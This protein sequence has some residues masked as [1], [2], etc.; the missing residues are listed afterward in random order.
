VIPCL[1]D[2]A[3]FDGTLVSVLQNRPA[4]CEI[5]VA[6]R[7][8]YDDPYGL[9]DEVNFLHCEGESLVELLNEA[10]TEASGE[11]LNIL[12]CGLEATENWT[13]APLAHF[14]DP[15]VASVS[16]LV[17]DRDQNLLA[18][19]VYCSL[20]GACRIAAN[21][22]V[23]EPG[24]GRLRAKILGPTLTAGFYRRD[25]IAALGGFDPTMTDQLA[26]VATALSLEALG[27]LHVVEPAS[28]LTKISD[29]STQKR[30]SLYR[31]RALERLYW[32]SAAHH[33]S[34]FALPLHAIHV[35]SDCARQLGE[36]RLLPALVGRGLGLCELGATGRYLE[37]LDAARQTLDE[38]ATLRANR[39]KRQ[40]AMMPAANESRRK[41][42]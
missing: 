9:A 18:A 15:D 10:L 16:P 6:H 41:A 38:L 27:K 21:P 20:G 4:N 3:E 34:V 1:G 12:G 33:G 11:V 25:C 5:V 30:S 26:D 35:V 29:P 17:F 36:L 42:A 39:F 37:Q 31:A 40:P 14:T 13:A 23:V 28:R 32:R 19:G 8:P 24:S 22:R 7:Q 2:A